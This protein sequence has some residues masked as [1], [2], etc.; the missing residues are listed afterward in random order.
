MIPRLSQ[1]QNRALTQVEVL[2]VLVILAV[3]IGWV[4]FVG[5]PQAKAKAIRINCLSNLKAGECGFRLWAGDNNYQYPMELSTNNGGAREW[6][7]QGKVFEVFRVLSNELSTPKVLFCPADN[8]VRANNF[9]TGFDN[10]NISYFVGVDA[11]CRDN[12]NVPEI[13]MSLFLYGD[14]NLTND[15]LP[16]NGIVQLTAN[17]NIRWTAELHKYEGNICLANGNVLQLNNSSLREAVQ[18]AAPATNRLV[19]P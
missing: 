9:A 12:T 6:L 16:E 8:R 1:Q 18:T 7:L 15:T 11:P 19:I 3:A 2:V 10:T 14:R 17:Q 5:L 13:K 4:I